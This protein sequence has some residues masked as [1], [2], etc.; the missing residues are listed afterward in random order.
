MHCKD[1]STSSTPN[2]GDKTTFWVT[3][4]AALWVLLL[5]WH[6]LS[7]SIPSSVT[8]YTFRPDWN[9]PWRCS[10][11]KILPTSTWSYTHFPHT[12]FPNT[13]LVQ[14]PHTPTLLPVSNGNTH[15]RLHQV[16]SVSKLVMIPQAQSPK[17]VL[18]LAALS[19]PN[20]HITAAT[21]K[22]WLWQLFFLCCTLNIHLT[23]ENW[24]PPFKT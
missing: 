10:S 2:T 4:I 3:Q 6:A 15:H 18:L 16:F 20:S 12:H 21:L 23:S 5:P 7:R 19:P 17:S 14:F 22:N 24:F 1:L 13:H 9:L 8:P 11:V